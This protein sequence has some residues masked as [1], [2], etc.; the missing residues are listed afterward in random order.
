MESRGWR[1][2]QSKAVRTGSPYTAALI[3][4]LSDMPW[5]RFILLPKPTLSS[6]YCSHR[7]RPPLFHGRVVSDTSHLSQYPSASHICFD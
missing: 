5:S 4:S 1:L 2:A 6:I 7:F 3:E